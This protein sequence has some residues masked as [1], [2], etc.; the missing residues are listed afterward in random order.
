MKQEKPFFK[1]IDEICKEKDIKQNLLSYGWIRELK[2]DEK[3]HYIMNYQFDL[4]SEISFKIAGDKFATYEVL[5]SNNVPT[6]THKIIFNPKTRS[7]YFQNKFIDEAKK[8]LSE[9]NNEIVIKANES[10]QG[11]DVYYCSK[12]NEIEDVVKKLFDENNDTLS[13]CPYLD[14]N[15]EYRA[16][17]LSGKI[18]YIYKKRKAYVIGNGINTVKELI[19]QKEINENIKIDICPNLNFDYIPKNK[20]EYTVSWKHNLNNGAEPIIIDEKDEFYE[21]VK[22][23]AISAGKALNIKFSTI[24]IAV[25]TD[26]KI[27]VMEVN[28]SVCMNKFSERVPNGYNIAK[29][30][31]KK[32]IDEMFV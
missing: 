11:K 28:A 25:T 19:N 29:S 17:Y 9:N 31:Y 5:K 21:S 6:I 7:K 13:A 27:F 16:I 23:I 20:E 24:D 22:N 1:M 8:M 12:E 15:Y 3:S 26:K 10:C 2:K 4:N 30:I 18:L 32:A 14:I